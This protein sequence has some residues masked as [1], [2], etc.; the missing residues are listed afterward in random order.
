MSATAYKSPL[1]KRI[2]YKGPILFV[3][4]I[5]I[6]LGFVNLYPFLWMLG[7]SFK[8]EAESSTDRMSPL[9]A[10]KYR[11]SDSFDF[12]ATLPLA[13]QPGMADLEDEDFRREL[14]TLRSKL[15]LIDRLQ[16]AASMNGVNAVVAG[17]LGAETDLP[18][19]TLLQEMIQLGL[20]EVEKDHS[21]WLSQTAFQ[22]QSAENSE[23]LE[24]ALLAIQESQVIRVQEYAVLA[25]VDE[26]R[27]RQDLNQLV[28][29]GML[30]VLPMEAGRTELDRRFVL[31]PYSRGIIHSGLAPRHILTLWDLHRENRKQAE[32]RSTFATSRIGVSE[33][34]SSYDIANEEEAL[35]ELAALQ[36][37]G[38]LTPASY[39]TMNYWV[40]LKGENFL[41]NFLTT[42]LLT[43]MVVLGTVLSSSM[44]GYAFA[45]MQFPGKFWILGTMIFASILPGEAR[46]IPI[47]KMLLSVNALDSLWGLMTW[48]V[49]FGVGNALLMAG[50]FLTLPKEVNEAAS[51]DGAGVFRTFFDIALPMA[52]PI[53]MTVGM[54]AFLTA[55]NDF[56]VPLLCTISRPSMQPLAVAVYNFQAG[57]PGKWHQIN[58]AASI[59]ILPVI[60]GFLLVQKHVVKSIAVGAVKG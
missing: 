56:M 35:L 44:L 13:L 18:P 25:K 49:A 45:S 40:V 58:A 31:Q 50:F 32:T 28:D 60:F 38:Y 30:Q 34:A 47:F 9:P 26:N 42:L 19:S 37:A 15:L 57:H 52:R 5:L 21:H 7:T 14:P 1:L 54:F 22:Y 39:Q 10:L 8:A 29:V 27:A 43:T 12:R 20:L 33:Y 46:V 23:E 6:T 11:L 16:R 2:R 53:V 41:L 17:S 51:V 55:W 24:N 36:E 59:M 3:H 4:L 48:L